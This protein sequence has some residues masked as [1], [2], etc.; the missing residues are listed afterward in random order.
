M[1]NNLP[2][3]TKLES[4]EAGIHTFNIYDSCLPITQDGKIVYN[5][6]KAR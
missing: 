6:M 2:N 1:L 5:P 4:G 3:N